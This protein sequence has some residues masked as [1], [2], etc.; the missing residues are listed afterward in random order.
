[1]LVFALA[2][3]CWTKSVLCNVAAFTGMLFYLESTLQLWASSRLC[4]EFKLISSVPLHP[5]GRQ[6]IPSGRSSVKAPSVRMNRT[7]FPDIMENHPAAIQSSR[8]IQ[9]SS[10]SVRKTWQYRSDAI[11][12]WTSNRVS[13][14][15]TDMGRQLQSS[16]RRGFPSGRAHP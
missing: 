3:F 2:A 11:Q 9:R 1:M 14:S 7:F 15:D 5:S 8:R 13:I 16:R 12:C 10:A 6:G 4:A